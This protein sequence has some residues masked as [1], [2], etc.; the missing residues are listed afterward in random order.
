MKNT[1]EFRSVINGVIDKSSSVQLFNWISY[2]QKS[3]RQKDVPNSNV[4][5]PAFID[6][7]PY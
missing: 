1:K 7:M 6:E 4:K 2:S 3:Y 5:L